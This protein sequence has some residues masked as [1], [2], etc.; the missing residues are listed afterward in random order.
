MIDLDEVI[1]I[2]QILIETFGGSPGVRDLNSLKSAINRPF[3]TFSGNDLYLTTLEK[4]SALVESLIVN[5]PFIDGN[6]RIGYV[7]MRLFLLKNHYDIF[8]N[9]DEKYNFIISI[10]SGNLNKEGINQWLIKHCKE[11]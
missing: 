2:H 4:A 3:S 10:A 7:L 6:K 8:C 1:S 5:H 9:E 11:I